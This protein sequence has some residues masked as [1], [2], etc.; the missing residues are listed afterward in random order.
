MTDEKDSGFGFGSKH[1]AEKEDKY[2]DRQRLKWTPWKDIKV[3]QK[4]KSAL[5]GSNGVVS[6]MEKLLE[7]IWIDWENG[8][9][10]R[11]SRSALKNV[12]VE[13]E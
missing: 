2:K 10:S 3:G 4:V 1:E 12:V 7:T 11:G 6:K 9:Q 13:E 5:T 8:K